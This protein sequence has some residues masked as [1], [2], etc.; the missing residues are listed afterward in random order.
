MEE[1][2]WWIKHNPYAPAD[3][4]SAHCWSAYNPFE[5]WGLIA[6]E[7]V[8]ASGGASR[9]G[10]DISALIK[11]WNLTLGLPFI[12]AGATIKEDDLDRVIARTPIKY[13]QGQLPLEPELLTVTVDVQENTM[14]WGIRAW[15]ILWDHPDWPMWSALIDWGEAVSWRQILELCGLVP[16]SNGRTRQFKYC[17]ATAPVAGAGDAPA[18]QERTYVVTAGLV[19]SGDGDKT[20]EVYEFC[21]A[22]AEIFSPYKGGDAS[23]TRGNTIHIAQV[24]EGE[25]DLVWAWSD[26]FAANLYYDCIKNG[27]SIAGPIFWWLPTNIDTHYRQQLTDEYYGKDDRGRKTFISRRKLNHLGD[28]EKMQRVL[29]GEIEERLDRIREERRAQESEK[30]KED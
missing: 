10:S 19:D 8:E 25:L 20:K 2:F 26:F 9:S 11:F 23:R 18:L 17:R 28:M 5:F 7:F 22:N 1:R 14:W 16:D 30:G 3:K 13:V 4:E 15:G 12:R 29:A 24:M 6:K 27:A 21:M